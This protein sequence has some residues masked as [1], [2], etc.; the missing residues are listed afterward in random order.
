ML[1][2]KEQVGLWLDDYPDESESRAAALE[3]TVAQLLEMV[4]IDLDNNDD[5][6]IIFETLNARG[7]PLLQSDLVKNY[8][9]VRSWSGH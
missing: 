3:H 5:P 8:R 2:F 9:N 7:T 1:F 4:V 6:H